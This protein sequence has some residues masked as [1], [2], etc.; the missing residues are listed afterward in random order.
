MEDS[1]MKNVHQSLNLMIIAALMA[2]LTACARPADKPVVMYP[3]P[4]YTTPQ[5]SEEDILQTQKAAEEEARRLARE[6]EE[7]RIAEERKM[8]KMVFQERKLQEAIVSTRDQIEQ[9]Q[10]S[11]KNGSCNLAASQ[12]Q[13]LKGN[14][15]SSDNELETD[16]TSAVCIC[17]LEV[18]GD[19][20]RFT[21]CSVDL[22]NLVV[23]RNYLSRESQ[24]VLALRPY[25]DGNKSASRDNRIDMSL[26][27]S[28][29]AI[30][31]KTSN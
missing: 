23:N 17:Y 10:H 11:I 28:L 27:N 12:A 19:V 20:E 21:K 14:V 24:L 13:T 4:I 18:E 29:E 5:M 26:T 15:K 22:Q 31:T 7:K 8:Q 2:T 25:L 1:T 30:F 3:T 9:F 6:K 16:L